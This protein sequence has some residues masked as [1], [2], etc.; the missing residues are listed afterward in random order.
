MTHLWT[1]YRGLCLLVILVG[2][3]SLY[4]VSKAHTATRSLGTWTK[5]NGESVS[6]PCPDVSLYGDKALKMPAGCVSLQPGVWISVQAHAERKAEVAKLSRE[7][8]LT[9]A[10]LTEYRENVKSER[11]QLASYFQSTSSELKSISEQI[12]SPPFSW[13]SAAMGFATG[14]AMCGGIAIGGAF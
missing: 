5:S 12:D 11:A 9:K 2:L 1:N 6:M 14:A 4:A 3:Q 13:Q 8:E 10:T 7:L